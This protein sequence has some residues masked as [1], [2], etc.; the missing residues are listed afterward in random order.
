MHIHQATMC[1]VNKLWLGKFN[2]TL[3][4]NI[5]FHKCHRMIIIVSTETLFNYDMRSSS[6][7]LKFIVFRPTL[8]LWKVHDICSTGGDLLEFK[9]LKCTHNAEAASYSFVRLLLK[10]VT[11]FNMTTDVFLTK[12]FTPTPPRPWLCKN[13]VLLMMKLT[14]MV[15]LFDTT[16]KPAPLAISRA[17]FGNT[18]YPVS[19]TFPKC[20]LYLKIEFITV[21]VISPNVSL[22]TIPPVEVKFLVA[23]CYN[24]I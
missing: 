20:P 7:N 6:S 17:P 5:Y 22:N 16:C 11:L 19:L 12:I 8:L 21:T 9:W 2:K 3:R 4:V 23:Q 24:I 13:W 1:V 14:K 18:V 15:G 10:N